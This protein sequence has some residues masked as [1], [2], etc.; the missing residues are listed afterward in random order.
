MYEGKKKWGSELGGSHRKKILSVCGGV[1]TV[2]WE[3][4]LWSQ[5]MYMYICIYVYVY[6][7]TYETISKYHHPSKRFKEWVDRLWSFW[8][9]PHPP[10]Q[11][12][13]A[14][15]SRNLDKYPGNR[16]Y[17]GR[18][19]PIVANLRC[20]ILMI[21]TAKRILNLHGFDFRQVLLG[22]SR[23]FSMFFLIFHNFIRAKRL[24]ISQS[25]N[26][27]WF[28][29]ETW[30]HGRVSVLLLVDACS[31]TDFLRKSAAPKPHNWFRH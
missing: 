27:K 19:Y 13:F 22:S 25:T 2:Q 5:L 26:V 10:V 11:A 29:Q 23:C 6:I 24:P 21:G 30:P 17:S 7:Y 8:V 31:P 14:P 9:C 1:Q 28:F 3:L 4:W 18:M 16:Q 12:V 15:G 20:E